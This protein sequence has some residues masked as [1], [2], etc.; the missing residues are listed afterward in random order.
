ML[1]CINPMDCRLAPMTLLAWLCALAGPAALASEPSHSCLPEGDARLEMRI[2]G[3]FQAEV[4]WGNAGTRCDGGPRPDGDALR[5]M[6]GRDDEGLLIVLGIAGLERAATGAGLQANV[7]IVRQGLGQFYGTL[8]AGACVVSVEENTAIAG[9][10][11]AYRVSGRGRCESPIE[12]INR[13][14]HI[15]VGPFEFT[16]LAFWPDEDRDRDD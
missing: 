3:D 2:T 5:L 8:G 15:R 6:F 7:T 10:I 14:G 12:A 13:D 1:L 11:D 9:M 4:R 16:G